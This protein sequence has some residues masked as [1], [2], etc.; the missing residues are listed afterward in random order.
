MEQLG[1]GSNAKVKDLKVRKESI[2]SNTTT[3]NIL[4]MRRLNISISDNKFSEHRLIL[5]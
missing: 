3:L 5:F 1:S 2:N 4:N